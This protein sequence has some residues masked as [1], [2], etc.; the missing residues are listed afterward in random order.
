[1]KMRKITGR[2]FTLWTQA[3]CHSVTS[4]QAGS[5][6]QKTPQHP[7]FQPTKQARIPD[8]GKLASWKTSEM[9]S[10]EQADRSVLWRKI[11]QGRRNIEGGT[12]T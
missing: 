7:Q 12:I 2:Y 4:I 6:I 3:A 9:H 1:M 10:M 5:L 11:R 8:H